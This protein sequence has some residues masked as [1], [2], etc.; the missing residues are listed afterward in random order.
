[1]D[2]IALATEK[3]WR[4]RSLA[5]GSPLH[6]LRGPVVEGSKADL[7]LA[8]V[9]RR[10]FMTANGAPT[11]KLGLMLTASSRGR[12]TAMLTEAAASLA[13]ERTQRGDLEA[14]GWIPDSM[15]EQGAAFIRTYYVPGKNGPPKIPVKD[16][17]NWRPF[18]SKARAEGQE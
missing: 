10:G 11:G 14:Y 2:L 4:T 9:G 1:M 15:A 17:P 18:K 13:F 7:D 6:P 12:L 16:Q 5:D 8:I 3:R